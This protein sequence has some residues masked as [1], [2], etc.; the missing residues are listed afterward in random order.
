[1][2]YIGWISVLRLDNIK[3]WLTTGNTHL[4]A[5]FKARGEKNTKLRTVDYYMESTSL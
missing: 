2:L 5:F 3:K 1:M 4:F